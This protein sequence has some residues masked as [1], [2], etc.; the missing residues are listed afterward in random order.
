MIDILNKVSSNK[1]RRDFT[2]E[3]ESGIKYRTVKLTKEEFQDE[4]K[5]TIDE[6]CYFLQT[7]KENFYKLD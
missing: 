6:W 1:T 3:M 5:T 7:D 4:E 2:F